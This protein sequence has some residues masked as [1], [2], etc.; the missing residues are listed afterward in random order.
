MNTIITFLKLIWSR[1]L[2]YLRNKYLLTLFLVFIWLTFFDRNNF[3]SRVRM[4]RDVHQLKN[5]CEYYRE[6]IVNDS[7]RL[8]ELHSSPEMLEKYAR[9]Q[10]LMKKDNEEI[11]IIVNR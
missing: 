6:K 2:P 5:D 8:V 11:F 3:I 9:E 4:I 7:A 1:L 10:Y